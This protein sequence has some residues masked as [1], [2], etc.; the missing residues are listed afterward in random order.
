MWLC[1]FSHS[2]RL[3]L[4]DVQTSISAFLVPRPENERKEGCI[5]LLKDTGYFSWVFWLEIITLPL[6]AAERL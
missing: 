4:T 5:L 1:P 3:R 6:L 2:Q